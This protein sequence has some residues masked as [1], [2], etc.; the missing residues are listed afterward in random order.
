MIKYDRISL[1][2]EKRKVEVVINLVLR[3]IIRLVK[4]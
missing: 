2:F 3:E 1:V 4:V